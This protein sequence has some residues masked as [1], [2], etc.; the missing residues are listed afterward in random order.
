MPCW[1]AVGF[2]AG[3]AFIRGA[4]NPSVLLGADGSL[5]ATSNKAFGE[6]VL[7]PT[8]AKATALKIQKM[9]V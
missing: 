5:G 8:C 3:K 7:T 4:I 6:V 1:S 9:I 2:V